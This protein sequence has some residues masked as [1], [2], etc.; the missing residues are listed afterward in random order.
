MNLST[1]HDNCGPYDK[2]LYLAGDDNGNA[3]LE[4]QEDDYYDENGD[5]FD[6]DVIFVEER[7]LKNPQRMRTY[8]NNSDLAV[9]LERDVLEAYNMFNVNNLPP[10][11]SFEIHHN[12]GAKKQRTSSLPQLPQVKCF[13]QKLPNNYV[14]QQPKVGNIKTHV[15]PHK[16]NMPPCD[17][18][19]GHYII[20]INDVFANRFVIQKLLG[21][22]TF[23]K[24]VA[25]YDKLNR[26]TVAIKIIRNIPKY[27]DAAKIELRVLTTLK[28]FDNENRN[29]CIHLRECFDFRG[30][31]CIVTDL[32]KISLYD[33]MENNK[34][35]PYPGSHIQAISK[36]LIRSI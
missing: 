20:R 26:E 8:R 2:N 35:I 10:T 21:Q 24:V 36:Q 29:H 17:D 6:N 15:I 30:H 12:M 27:R 34:F 25:C 18:E 23:G 19:D 9:F 33:F 31:I 5:I 22:G 11:L 13:Y 28:Q 1:S 3:I 32:L 7:R 16:L 4:E 14:H